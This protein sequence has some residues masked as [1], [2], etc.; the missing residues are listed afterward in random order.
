VPWPAPVPAPIGIMP[1][2]PAAGRAVRSPTGAAL[3]GNG[4][5]RSGRAGGGGSGSAG[6]ELRPGLAM[7][8]RSPEAIGG[9]VL[10]GPFGSTP[11]EPLCPARPF[12]LPPPYPVPA[13]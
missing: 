3:D 12:E 1:P 8:D 11:P 10:D 9:Q 13:P 4:V 7:A 2:A 5:F 6:V